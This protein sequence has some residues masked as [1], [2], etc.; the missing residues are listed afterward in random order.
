[1][2][3]LGGGADRLAGSAPRA[4][5]ALLGDHLVRRTQR[6]TCRVRIVE[7]EAYAENDPASH[8]YE[9]PTPRSR[10]MFGPPGHWYVYRCYGIHWMLNAVCGP[11]GTGEA[12]LIRAAQP[13]EGV[14]L[15][16]RRR[17]RQD[18]LLDG[19]GKLAEALA[20]DDELQGTPIRPGTGLHLEGRQAPSEVFAGPRVGIQDAR[21]RPWR[22]FIDSEHVSSTPLN[23]RAEPVE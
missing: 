5:R 10:V 13:L 7:T 2:S 9:G 12:V 23:D 16:R 3:L 8:S 18:D 4:A 11:D 22:F 21:E 19:P 15:M 14:R 20:V 1:M 6:G 17:G